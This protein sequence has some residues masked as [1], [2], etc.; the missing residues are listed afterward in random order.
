MNHAKRA[1]AKISWVVA[2]ISRMTLYDLHV[3]ARA[4]IRCFRYLAGGRSLAVFSELAFETTAYCNRHCPACPVSL[5]PRGKE[6]M[7][8]TLF[9]KVLAEL[10]AINYSGRIALH[11]FNEPL[12][13]KDIVAKVRRIGEAA[14]RAKIEIFSNGDFL[15]QELARELFDAGLSF[16]L[17]T[18]Y[19][20]RA[21]KR[22]EAL[23][24]QLG[25]RERRRTVLR[26]ATVLASNRAGTLEQLAIPQSLKADCFQPS[27]KLVVNF[28]GEAVI[29]SNDYFAKSIVGNIAEQSLLEIWHGPALQEIRSLLRQRRRDK[30]PACKGCN[31]V[32]TPIGFHYLS[33]ADSVRF[34][35]RRKSKRKTRVIELKPALGPD[36]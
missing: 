33:D 21:M 29:C 31:I 18:A 9:A 35:A 28:R 11:F 17:L 16:I 24:K 13:D 5:A 10:A 6:V 22:L 19:N 23:Q 12:A 20:D 3:W 1:F 25:R 32:S 34:N 15:T 7:D 2:A 30:L 8:E 26:R 36:K 27:Y 14:P 4:W